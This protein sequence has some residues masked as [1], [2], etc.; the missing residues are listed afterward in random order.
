M[1]NSADDF[2]EKLGE[3]DVSELL[4]LNRPNVCS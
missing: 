4:D 1:A 3:Q 2:M